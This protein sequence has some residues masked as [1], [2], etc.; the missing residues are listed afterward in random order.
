MVLG[1]VSAAMI[2][3]SVYNARSWRRL[4]LGSFSWRRGRLVLGYVA[5][6]RLAL[7]RLT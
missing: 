4:V 5:S 1:S 2:Y 6:G 7:G 3:N